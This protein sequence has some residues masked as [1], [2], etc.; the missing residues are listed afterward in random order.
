MRA[1]LQLLNEAAK[2]FA[3]VVVIAGSVTFAYSYVEGYVDPV[4]GPLSFEN[5]HRT[6]DEE[7]SVTFDG[8]AQKLRACDWVESR[9]YVGERFEPSVRTVWAFTGPPE[10]RPEGTL[11]WRDMT[12][13]MTAKQFYHNS[14]ADVVH[15]CPWS[16]WNTITPFYD[17]NDD[18]PIPAYL[19]TRPQRN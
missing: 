19:A 17:S 8:V 14:H 2:V 11:R 1:F 9:W 6:G 3:T 16:A 12:V 18:T 15:K 7:F 5:V 10:V 13:Q 4:M